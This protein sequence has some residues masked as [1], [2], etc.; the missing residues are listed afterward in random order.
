MHILLVEDDEL[1]GHGL[2]SALTQDQYNVYWVMD[3][4]MAWS[5][6]QTKHFDMVILDLKLPKLSGKDI[7]KNMRS[8][9]INIP[10]IILTAYDNETEFAE[11]FGIGADDYITKPFD[12]DK[13]CSR[14]RTIQKRTTP[15]LNTI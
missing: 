11:D 7:L 5:A 6:L 9:N 10:I 13:L 12:L 8:N 15:R 14:I 3:G 4:I 1:L 2:H